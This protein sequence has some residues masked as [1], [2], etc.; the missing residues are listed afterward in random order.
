LQRTI[1]KQDSAV[2]GAVRQSQQTLN[3]YETLGFDGLSD[4]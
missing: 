3:C 4:F 1:V 2:I